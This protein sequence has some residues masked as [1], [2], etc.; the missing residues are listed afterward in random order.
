MKLS[1]LYPSA[2][3]GHPEQNLTPERIQKRGERQKGMGEKTGKKRGEERETAGESE[4]E[5]ER[6][7]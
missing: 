3:H 2:A 7:K 1:S 4:R 6:E 5:K